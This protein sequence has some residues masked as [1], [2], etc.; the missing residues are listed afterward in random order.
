MFRAADVA[1]Y[2]YLLGQCG[3]PSVA[4]QNASI[5]TVSPYKTGVRD[6]NT[7]DDCQVAAHVA[8]TQHL[9]L[10]LICYN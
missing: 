4:Y 1:A 3:P 9:V 7:R 5:D 2:R 8:R 10:D 6:T